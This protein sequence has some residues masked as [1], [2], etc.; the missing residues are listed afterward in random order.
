MH[1]QYQKYCKDI[2]ETNT[3]KYTCK[4]KFQEIRNAGIREN[5]EQQRSC[6]D[7]KDAETQTYKTQAK[8]NPESKKNKC[9]FLR[10]TVN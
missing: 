4:G 6:K 5:G 9:M 1:H 2:R 10:K 8:G 7:I 3:Q